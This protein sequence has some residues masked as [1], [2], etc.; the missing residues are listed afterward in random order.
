[1]LLSAAA[2]AATAAVAATAATTSAS[3]GSSSGTG[4]TQAAAGQAATAGAVY[5]ALAADVRHARSLP[6][7]DLV[8]R[9][10]TGML[11]C[12]ALANVRHR[13]RLLQRSQQTHTHCNSMC[14]NADISLSLSL[15]ILYCTAHCAAAAAAAVQQ[16]YAYM[17]I[18]P[19]RGG[20]APP[21]TSAADLPPARLRQLCE[22]LTATVVAFA[23]D[24]EARKLLLLQ[25]PGRVQ[26]PP[27][28]P[29]T[30]AAAPAAPVQLRPQSH[31]GTLF[32]ALLC[33]CVTLL[34]RVRTECSL[35]LRQLASASAAI[36]VTVQNAR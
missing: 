2:A 4:G 36:A 20:D 13:T 35:Y 10:S 14:S 15:Q 6:L 21:A 17:Q 33:M 32:V 11:R 19:L 27:N 18:L 5:T 24:R 7:L 16:L 28:V 9:C 34:V 30:A 12:S 26:R 22:L 31:G 8:S 25:G 29:A 3:S 1:M 23:R